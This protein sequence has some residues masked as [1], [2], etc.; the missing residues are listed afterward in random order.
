MCRCK[1]MSELRGYHEEYDYGNIETSSP[2]FIPPELSPRLK[3]GCMSINPQCENWGSICVESATY[4]LGDTPIK[5][6]HLWLCR[7]CADLYY[8]HERMYDI[9]EQEKKVKEAKFNIF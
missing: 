5:I 8:Y 3:Y 2:T 7:D 9:E 1:G 4:L 6:I